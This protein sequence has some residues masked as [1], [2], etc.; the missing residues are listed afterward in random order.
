MFPASPHSIMVLWQSRSVILRAATTLDLGI[1]SHQ[2]HIRHT[3]CRRK[4]KI[5]MEK[6]LRLLNMARYANPI[7]KLVAN[8]GSS[9]IQ[10]GP[11]FVDSLM[12]FAASLSFFTSACCDPSFSNTYFCLFTTHSYF[13][14]SVV[15]EVGM[16]GS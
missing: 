4:Y 5:N 9:V 11:S 15:F 6:L 13:L 16:N 3:G 8:C 1:H 10:I 12:M 2:V 7:R 14:K